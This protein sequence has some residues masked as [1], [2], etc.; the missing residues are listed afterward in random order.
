VKTLFA[1]WM[2]DDGVL[3][4][5]PSLE[6]SLLEISL[7]LQL[8]LFGFDEASTFVLLPLTSR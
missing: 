6:T 7:G 2:S 4:V 3:G 1:L 5:V 8:Q